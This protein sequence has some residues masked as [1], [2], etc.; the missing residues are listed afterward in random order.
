MR[1]NEN[2]QVAVHYC[3]L[4]GEET[5]SQSLTTC[6]ICKKEMCNRDGYGLHS[7]YSIEIY[8]YSDAA[9]LAP[10]RSHVCKDCAKS[11]PGLTIAEFFDVAMSE[12][13]LPIARVA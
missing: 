8:R 6:A 2:R 4:C 12:K 5:P 13:P 10:S 11:N 9:S 7:A 1:K 3:D